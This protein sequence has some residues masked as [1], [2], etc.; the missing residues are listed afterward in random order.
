MIIKSSKDL[1]KVSEELHAKNYILGAISGSFDELH[2]GHKFSITDCS[3]KVDKLFVLINSD[4]SV[5]T[6]KGNQRPIQELNI[7]LS[8]LEEFN[9]E[10]IIVPFYELIPNNLLEIIMPNKYFLSSEW[11]KNPVEKPVL[12]KINC[13]IEDHPVLANISTSKNLKISDTSVGAIFLDRDGT[14][15]EDVGYLDSLQ[16][17]RISQENL[18]AL[19]NLSNLNLLNI[20]ITNQSGVGQNFFSIET[21]HS[22]N[23]QII[24][25]IEQNNGKIDKLYYDTS[26]KNNPSEFRKPNIGMILKARVDFN[27]SLKKSW[28]IGDKDSDIELGKKCNMKSIYIINKKYHYE[29]FFKPDFTV[30]NLS[31]AYE[32]ISKS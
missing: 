10:I 8:S 18:P 5:K 15:N 7:R 6:Y 11:I 14:I 9:N 30:N 13:S 4:E 2:D 24:K 1:K 17:I 27:I 12:E 20:I 25:L 22:I 28:I 3:R 32:I 23:A 31:E 19:N 21:L 16:D 26:T 29:S